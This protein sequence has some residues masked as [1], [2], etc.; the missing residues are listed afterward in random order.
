M[1]GET[2]LQSAIREMPDR[3]YLEIN[4]VAHVCL[5]PPPLSRIVFVS[6]L[7]K[8]QAD[9]E[10]TLLLCLVIRPENKSK[11]TSA[12]LYAGKKSFSKKHQEGQCPTPGCQVASVSPSSLPSWAAISTGSFE[13]KTLP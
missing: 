6:G 8:R 9:M 2:C 13:A 12:S 5:P 10:R 3:E 1:L 7:G 11:Y 4:M